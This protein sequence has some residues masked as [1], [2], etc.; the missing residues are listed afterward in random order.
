MHYTHEL[1][2]CRKACFFSGSMIKYYLTQG[3]YN[4]SVAR[5]PKM[6]EFMK[7]NDLKIIDNTN[8]QTLIGWLNTADVSHH[9]LI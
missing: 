4:D 8:K 3:K 1:P 6:V 5:Y 9:G 2:F 7:D